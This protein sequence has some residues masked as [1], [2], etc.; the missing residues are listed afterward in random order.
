MDSTN[1]G[2]SNYHTLMVE[3]RTAHSRGD[4]KSAV[5][6]FTV[7]ASV[8]PGPTDRAEAER[9]AQVSRDQVRG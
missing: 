9:L 6:L 3:A 2:S 7:A 1:L 8:A 4:Y 5:N